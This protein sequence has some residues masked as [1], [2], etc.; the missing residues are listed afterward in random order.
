MA[1]Y[2]ATQIKRLAVQGQ[3]RSKVM[4]ATIRGDMTMGARLRSRLRR[5]FYF[6]LP[7]S[8]EVME[9]VRS[10]LGRMRTGAREER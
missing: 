2:L 8:R 1:E 7:C 10:R 4:A 9:A 3:L 6:M 5:G